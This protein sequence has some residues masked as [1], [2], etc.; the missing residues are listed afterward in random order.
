MMILYMLWIYIVHL[1]MND[2]LI[3]YPLGLMKREVGATKFSNYRDK[4][5]ESVIWY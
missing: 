3:S 1:I 4:E 2:E 5:R